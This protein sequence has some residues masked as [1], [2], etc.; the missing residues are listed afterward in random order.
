MKK[1]SLIVILLSCAL[2]VYSQAIRYISDDLEVPARAG[3]GDRFKITKSLKTGT[4]VQVLEENKG[5]GYS[6]VKAENNYQGWVYTR[7][8]MDTPSARNYIQEAK[9]QY[10]PARLKLIELENALSQAKEKESQLL[11]RIELLQT[12]SKAN[13]EKLAEFKHVNSKSI[14]IYEKSQ[15]LDQE[16]ASLKQSLK[17]AQLDNQKL[18]DAA[19]SWEQTM[20]ATIF[21]FGIFLGLVVIPRLAAR[22]RKRNHD[23]L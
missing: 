15:L 1:F 17:N 22:R 20:G 16:Q 7:Y 12:E 14:E 10:E 4:K 5:T 11:E 21:G 9:D 3:A 19:N 13:A 6:L 18:K 23:Y 2:P 8:L